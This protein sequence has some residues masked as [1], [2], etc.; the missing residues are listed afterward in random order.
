[1]LKTF[2]LQTISKHNTEDDGW[3]IINSKVYNVSNFIDAHPGGKRIIL[4]LLGKDATQEFHQYHTGKT[5][6]AKYT[7]SL[8]IGSVEERK[9]EDDNTND[10]TAKNFG[11]MITFADP[12]WYQA[13]KSPY[14]NDS[15]RRLRHW[16]RNFI[17]VNVIPFV[18]QWEIAGKVPKELYQK[19]G[20]AGYLNG[21]L[22]QYPW[23]K[24][25]G[26]PPAGIKPEEFDVF[27]EQILIDELAR[28]ASAGVGFAIS[29]GPSIALPAILNFAN[30]DL[31]NL[32]V[33]PVLEGKKTIC[34]CITEPYAGSDVA[35][36]QTTATLSNCGEH[37][38]ING[39]KKWITNGTWADYFIVAAR[40]G[41]QGMTGIT[42]FLLKREMVG[43]RTRPIA[44]Q[45]NVGSGTAF[46]IF[47]NVKVP[48]ENIIGELNHGFKYIM[49][50][51]N[52]K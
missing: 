38:L 4:P 39:E 25:V 13:W 33:K 46:V 51:F 43:L 10:P 5:V 28:C 45:G 29:L 50:N 7:K 3:L 47:E 8:L 40:T 16:A 32:I 27:H 34:L 19:F 37:Y 44:C 30:K 15:H 49:F 52:R 22:G 14:Y 17:E 26:P 2:D 21:I 41:R 36:I 6:L 42:L 20:E 1:M 9:A 48:K 18:Y 12:S 11:S 24:N 23:P 35:S 31:V